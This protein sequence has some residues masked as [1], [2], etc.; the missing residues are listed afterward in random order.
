M[1]NNIAH[2][3]PSLI[4]LDLG[5]VLIDCFP[6]QFADGAS[7][8]STKTSQDVFNRYC[9]GELKEAFERGQTDETAFF[10]E[11]ADGLNIPSNQT[12]KLKALWSDIF[13]IKENAEQALDELAKIYPVWI[14]SDTNITHYRYSLQEYPFIN[15]AER[16]IASFETGF[17]KKDPGA[18]EQVIKKA[19]LNPHQILFLDDLEINV[20]AAKRAGIQA[21]I[22]NNWTEWG[23]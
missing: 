15:K 11:M 14:L 23:F 9:G 8:L 21:F 6:W 2:L 17:L 3:S 19:E 16:F 18:F 13:G 22:F 20:T 1:F 7:R 5:N 10:N 4:L 12:G